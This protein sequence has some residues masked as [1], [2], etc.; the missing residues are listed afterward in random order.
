[1]RQNSPNLANLKE[2]IAASGL[3]VTQ[4]RMAILKAMHETE[5]H[6]SAEFLYKVLSKDYPALS[7]GTVYKTLDSLV[8]KGLVRKV[9][10]PD[11]LKRYDVHTD[12]HS[13]L[14]CQD[15]QKIIDFEDPELEQMIRSY[16]S[17]K[18]VNNFRIEDIQLQISGI[19]LEAGKSVSIQ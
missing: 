12:S 11:G 15:S 8:E 1:M 10:C 18:K 16:L 3:K 13:H 9:F 14:Y 4:Q 19:I 6:P 5:E 17:R 7:L 2:K